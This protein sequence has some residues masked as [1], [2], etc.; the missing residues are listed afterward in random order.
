MPVTT[1]FGP[2]NFLS[3]IRPLHNKGSRD[4]SDPTGDKSSLPR[5][6]IITNDHGERKQ[7]LPRQLNMFVS[8]VNLDNQIQ[9][10]KKWGNPGKS[11]RVDYGSSAYKNQL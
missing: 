1:T 3:E 5:I 6:N 7:N 9:K 4:R 2:A 8:E 11:P 10:H